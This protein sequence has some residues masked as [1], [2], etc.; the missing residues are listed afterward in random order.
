[1]KTQLL[2]TAQSRVLCRSMRLNIRMRR[3][4][5]A[6]TGGQGDNVS[7]AAGK[8]RDDAGDGG[9]GG[10]VKELREGLVLEPAGAQLAVSS[11]APTPY[12]LPLWLM[13]L[14]CLFSSFIVFHHYSPFMPLS[15]LCFGIHLPCQL[16]RSYCLYLFVILF[17]LLLMAAGVMDSQVRTGRILDTS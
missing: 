14:L 4:G 8:G 2:V 13:R 10:M 6:G 16:R 11:S 5:K 15:S 1:M 12:S 7:A 17:V 3:T 9:E